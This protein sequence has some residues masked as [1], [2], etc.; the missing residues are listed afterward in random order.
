METY[1]CNTDESSKGNLGPSVVEF[2]IRNW[3]DD[4]VCVASYSL[5]VK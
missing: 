4:F 2:R 5:R 3:N 1:K